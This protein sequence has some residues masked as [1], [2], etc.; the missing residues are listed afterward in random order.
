MA[1][2]RRFSSLARLLPALDVSKIES[3]R[4]NNPET[5]STVLAQGWPHRTMG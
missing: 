5:I 2:R 1:L 4:M 3:V